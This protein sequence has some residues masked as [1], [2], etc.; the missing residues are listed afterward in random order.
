MELQGT[1]VNQQLLR[2]PVLD[3]VSSVLDNDVRFY[4]TSKSFALWSIEGLESLT[5][6][7][8]MAVMKQLR[9]PMK[10]A[11]YSEDDAVS[12]AKCYRGML[13][14]KIPENVYNEIKRLSI[15]RRRKLIPHLSLMALAVAMFFGALSYDLH[16]VSCINGIPED[17]ISYNNVTQTVEL[18]FTDT[19]IAF[20]RIS[21]FLTLVGVISIIVVAWWFYRVTYKVVGIMEAKVESEISSE[22]KS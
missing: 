9:K 14:N 4:V 20:Q 15:M 11:S 21:V 10:E 18:R 2:H 16:L 6:L 22:Q 3:A 7:W 8:H 12:L 13:S 19:A 1:V 17:S 5:D